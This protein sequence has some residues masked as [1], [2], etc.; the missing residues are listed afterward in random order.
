[1]P[2]ASATLLPTTRA[3]KRRQLVE[4]EDLAWWP[5]TLRDAATDY[6]AASMRVA[7]A[8]EAVAPVLASALTRAGANRIVDLC[9]GAGGPWATLVPALRARGVD[10]DVV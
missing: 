6:R 2:A 9:S 1:V 5:R 4:L 7:K 10:A 3:V 8:H